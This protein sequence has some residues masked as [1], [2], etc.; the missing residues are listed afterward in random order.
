MT[1]QTPDRPDGDG[2]AFDDI[3]LATMH[4]TINSAAIRALTIKHEGVERPTYSAILFARELLKRVIRDGAEGACE[5]YGEAQAKL[6]NRFAFQ[7]HA[8]T[9]SKPSPTTSCAADYGDFRCCFP[10][11]QCPR[12]S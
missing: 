4:S 7:P 12:T 1:D 9:P 8:I 6:N 5:T 3:V 10:N 11:C 2:L